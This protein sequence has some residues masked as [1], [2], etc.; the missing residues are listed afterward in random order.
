MVSSRQAAWG[1]RRYIG[2]A[3]LA[4]LIALPAAASAQSTGKGFLFK[5]PNGSFSMRMGY[6]A[7][8]TSSEPFKVLKRE[9]TLGQRSLD[10]FNLGIDVNAFLTPRVDLVFTMEGSSRTTTA[11]YREWEENGSPITHTS[12]LDRLAFGAGVRYNLVDRGRQISALAFIPA[13][14]IPY[15]GGTV[16]ALW[17]DFVQEGDFV[18]VVNDSTGNIFTDKLESNDYGLMGQ[19]YAGIERR[20]SPRWSLTG[21]TR[22][23][24]ST[25]KLVKD[26][27]GMGD[28]Q[29]S[30]L[31]FNIGAAVRF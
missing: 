21:E 26:Y 10:A 17:Y 31:A 30:G 2:G 4:A 5:K 11:E 7:A 23:T 19:V 13:R 12:T 28:I 18:E 1:T 9:T 29:L 14:T 8:N 25:A 6:E 27:R 20:L 3:L 22:Y 16:G 24:H 15:I